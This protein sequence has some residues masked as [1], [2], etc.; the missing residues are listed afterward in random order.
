MPSGTTTSSVSGTATTLDTM[1]I[2]AI[3]ENHHA[4][5]GAVATVAAN[6]TTTNP[7]AL[8]TTRAGHDAFL[9]LRARAA[10][11]SVAHAATKES[12]NET[13]KS[14]AGRGHNNTSAAKASASPPRKRRAAK[15]AENA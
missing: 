1:P 4:V 12:W 11:V 7:H 3:W 13:S 14:R 8:A 5:S 9:A 10:T 2:G 15:T 6:D